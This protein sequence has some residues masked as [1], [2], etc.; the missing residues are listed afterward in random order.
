MFHLINLKI[1][2]KS[3]FLIKI[4]IA[5]IG[6][7]HIQNKMALYNTVAPKVIANFLTLVL[8]SLSEIFVKL[9]VNYWKISDANLE[10]KD[11]VIRS[12]DMRRSAVC[13]QFHWSF[14][15]KALHRLVLLISKSAAKTYK[16]KIKLK[17]SK[18]KLRKWR[19]CICC[20]NFKVVLTIF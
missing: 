11:K 12:A 15:K 17:F 14:I 2:T 3:E 13:W 5:T 8:L 19:I 18:T 7:H 1:T 4:R 16:K 20:K 6:Y 10:T 9:L